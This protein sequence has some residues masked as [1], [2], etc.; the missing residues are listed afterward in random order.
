[1]FN[2]PILFSLIKGMFH[3]RHP[4]RS[5]VPEWDL[6][7]VLQF[8]ADPEV[9]KLYKLSLLELSQHTASLLAV[10]CGR[11]CS[12]MHVLS[13]LP[14]HMRF[15]REGV[16]LLLR[17]GYRSKNQ[18]LEHTPESIFLPDL[19]RVTIIRENATLCPVHCQIF[20]LDCTKEPIDKLLITFGQQNPISKPA[21]SP[22]IIPLVHRAYDKLGKPTSHLQAHDTGGHSPS[23][24][25]Y[26]GVPLAKIIAIAGW[27]TATTFQHTY[28]HDVLVARELCNAGPA[29]AR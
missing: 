12:E 24:A 6:P 5:L 17:A 11:H 10:A 22:W 9:C 14:H 4:S 21:P 3:V 15:S 20:Y 8:L 27:H 26:S 1:M 23:C 29:V 28:L 18:C 13:I 19:H 7:T 25:L 16:T 2:S